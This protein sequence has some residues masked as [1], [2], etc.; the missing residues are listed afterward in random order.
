VVAAGAVR[1]DRVGRVDDH[2]AGEPLAVLGDELFERVEPD[3]DHEH[4]GPIDRLVDGHRF[5]V[6]AEGGGELAGGLLVA[7]G[8][9]EVLTTGCEVRRELAADGADADDGNRAVRIVIL[10]LLS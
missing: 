5:G 9:E 6:A 4:V 1:P 8:Q 3:G 2:L 10:V 7:A